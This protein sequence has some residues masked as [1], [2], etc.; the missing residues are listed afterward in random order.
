MTGY[1]SA[2][3]AIEAIRAGAFDYIA[4]PVNMEQLMS[5]LRVWLT[6]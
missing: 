5:L 6:R 4:K 3:G 1:G 2:D